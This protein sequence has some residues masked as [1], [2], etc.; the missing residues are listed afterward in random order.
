MKI[1]A[2]T[3]RLILQEIEYSDAEDLYEM[4][5]DPEVHKLIEKN[6]VKSMEEME[7]VIRMIQAQYQKNGIGRW[8]VVNK[9][10]LEC[11]GWAGLR[12]VE[13]LTNNRRHYYDLGYRFKQKHWGQGYATEA[14]KACIQ[15][16]FE[17]INMDFIVAMVDPLQK[18]KKN[19]LT[20][21]GFTYRE[22]FDYHGEPTEWFELIKNTW[23][24]R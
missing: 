20:K 6:P 12:L 16:G 24:A 2:E 7:Q 18:K 10:T 17:H 19:V 4:D 5:S 8:A 15:Y 3:P 1:K 23:A 14:S 13:E 9:I 22:S 21:L 11:L